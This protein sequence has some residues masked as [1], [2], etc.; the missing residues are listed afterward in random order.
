MADAWTSQAREEVSLNIGLLARPCVVVSKHKRGARRSVIGWRRF[1]AG[2][3]A[4][5]TPG[6][7]IQQ[8]D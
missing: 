5:V 6:N 3:I 7:G 1:R 2:R 8:H 4:T